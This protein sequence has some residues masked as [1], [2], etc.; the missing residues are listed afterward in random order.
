MGA[1]LPKCRISNVLI[2]S[3]PC[4]HTDASITSQ[5][6]IPCTESTGCGNSDSTLHSIIS[7][8]GLETFAYINRI[9]VLTKLCHSP[10]QASGA[11]NYGTQCSFLKC[12]HKYDTTMTWVY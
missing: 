6:N 2:T 12:G 4:H 8:Y 9:P 10:L 7:Y 3:A 5:I 11:S 1:L